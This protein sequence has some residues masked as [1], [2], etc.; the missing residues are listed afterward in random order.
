MSRYNPEQKD[1]KTTNNCPA[2]GCMMAAS[3]FVDGGPWA[4][5]YHAKQPSMNW[6]K[7]TAILHEQRRLLDI[8]DSA[9][10][11]LPHEFDMLRDADKFELEDLLKPAR[12]VDGFA[13]ETAKGWKLRV[14]EFVYAAIQ[15][16]IEKIEAQDKPILEREISSAVAA[17]TGGNYRKQQRTKSFKSMA[18][19]RKTAD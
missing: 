5:R 16:V 3:V 4:C 14:S 2:H 18:E 7:V 10:K 15:Q 1:E 9:D 12:A 13:A 8:I 19:N 11:I 17:F 6:Q